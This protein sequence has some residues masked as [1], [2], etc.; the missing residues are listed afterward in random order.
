[1]KWFFATNKEST[2]E[3]KNYAEF[4]KVAILSAKNRAPSLDPYCLYDGPEDDFCK[5][6][7]N[8]GVKVIH[9]RI[10]FYDTFN[11]S[12][13]SKEQWFMKIATGAYLRVD[14]P[15]ILQKEN[16]KDDIILYTDCD[17]MFVNDIKIQDIGPINILS[18]GPESNIN[19]KDHINTGVV[20]FNSENIKKEYN[21]FVEYIKQNF[22]AS[23]TYDQDMFNQYFK[24]R[25]NY[26][27]PEF[28]WKPYWGYNSNAKII[29][30]HGPKPGHRQSIRERA[31]HIPDVFYLLAKGGYEQYSD[32]WF[33]YLNNE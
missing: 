31:D 15:L 16:I 26:M 21:S 25:W 9:H 5:W 13:K 28:N 4:V 18:A 6:M 32:E 17:V 14:I 23:Q 12:E 20:F 10:S 24:N 1:M 7:T 30:F 19:S 8:K 11:T 27:N 33:E 22:T 3:D 29:H 2:L